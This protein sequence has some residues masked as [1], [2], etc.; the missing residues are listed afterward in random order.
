MESR[1]P[2]HY[3]IDYHAIFE[4]TS[5]PYLILAPNPPKYTIIDANNT[6]LKVTM[7][8]RDIIGRP[9]FEAFPDNPEESGATG[10]KNLRASL[11][12][13]MEY[14]IPD[15][16]AL[17]KYDIARPDGTFE[18]RWWSPVNSP[19]FLSDGSLHCIIHHVEDVTGF[20]LQRMGHEKRQAM[21]ESVSKELTKKVEN[22]EAEIFIRGQKLQE[23]NEQLRKAQEQIRNLYE[24]CTK[25]SKELERSNKDLEQFSYFVSHDL[26]EPLRAV[27]GFL[28]NLKYDYKDTLNEDA[29]DDIAEAVGGAQRM[30]NLIVDLLTFSRVSRSGIAFK[31]IKMKDAVDDAIE[32]LFAAV[33]ENKAKITIEPLP[34][35]HADETQMTL[36][37]QNLIGNAIKYRSNKQPEILI[38]AKRE[39]EQWV[40]SV[41]DNGIGIDPKYF[42]TIFQMFQ[43]LFTREEYQG[44][45]IGLAV[46]KRIVERHGGKIWVESKSGEGSKFFFSIPDR[47]E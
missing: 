7:T 35:V 46:C 26:Q 8:T 4:Q 33:E 2:L 21:E 3:D 20:V 22:T 47:G 12:R 30:Q 11:D 24:N 28:S 29:M 16:M 6:R 10:V 38:N 5:S 13:V 27:I 43:R 18:E 9:L 34:V 37:F 44:T 39:N 15:T 42:E 32:N 36:L 41:S 1:K 17:Q 25:V 19:V 40:F 23:A 31:P 14:K 45:G